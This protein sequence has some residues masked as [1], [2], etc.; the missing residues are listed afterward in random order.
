MTTREEAQQ[1][2]V[3][4]MIRVLAR[5]SKA[6]DLL[7][8]DQQLL[9]AEAMRDTADLIDRGVVVRHPALPPRPRRWLVRSHKTQDGIPLFK[10]WR[11][12]AM[13]V[14]EA[15]FEIARMAVARGAVEQIDVVRCDERS[16]MAHIFFR[17]DDEPA[18]L[19]VDLGAP[20]TEA[21]FDHRA[22][23]AALLGPPKSSVH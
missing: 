23:A 13:R 15:S 19:L 1:Q 14:A 12:S 4:E 7:T 5:W 11:V 16:A 21:V 9:V 18:T 8:V 3:S 10:S 2:I 20:T 6:R 22:L 17:N